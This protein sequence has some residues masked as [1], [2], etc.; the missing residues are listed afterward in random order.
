MMWDMDTQWEN[1]ENVVYRISRGHLLRESVFTS[2]GKQLPLI[3]RIKRKGKRTTLFDRKDQANFFTRHINQLN[4]E[5]GE[6][7]RK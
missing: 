7:Q 2:R 4:R 1:E 5:N 3:G 6:I